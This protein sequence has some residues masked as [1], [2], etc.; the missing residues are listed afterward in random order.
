MK[1]PILVALIG[2][3]IGIVW[4]LYLKI[5]IA[6]FVLLL[7]IILI[8]YKK[9]HSII[10]LIMITAIISNIEI[11]TINNKC[12]NLQNYFS[13]ESDFV[14]TVIS[15]KI[16]GDYFN[17]YTI[18]ISK[19]NTSNKFKNVKLLLRTKKEFSYGD[20][21]SFTG[22]YVKGEVQRNYL[23]FDYSEYLKTLEIYGIC[24]NAKDE[25]I[26]KKNNLNKANL[27]LHDT[28]LRIKQNIEIMLKKEEA[29]LLIALITGD[30]KVSDKIKDDFRNS[31]I[32]HMLAISGMH[33]A[34]I[35]LILDKITTKLSISKNKKKWIQIIGIILFIQLS[36]KSI[37]IL[38]A[39]IMSILS[40]FA[41]ISKRKSDTINNICI[42]MLIFLF[43]N[44]FSI[45]N[46]SFQ[47]SFGGVIGIVLLNDNYKKLLV[48]LNIKGKI[49]ESIASILSAQTMIIPVII[50]NYHT[51]SLTFI[52]SNLLAGL[53]I[54]IIIIYGLIITVISFLSIQISVIISK[55]LNILIQMLI[56]IAHYG[57]LLPFSRIYVI[58]PRIPIIII[59]YYLILELTILKKIKYK[60][61]K[62]IFNFIINKK[63]Y[64]IVIVILIVNI[65]IPKDL[66]IYFIDVGQ[67]DSTLIVTPQNKRILIDSGGSLNYD[68]GN[69][70]LL[71]YLLNRGI[72]RI[73]YIIISHFDTD[74]VGGLLEII[75]EL[76][77][78]KI[79]ISKQAENSKNFQEFI[80]IVKEK[81][82]N[83]IIVGASDARP[84]ILQIE[85]DIYFDILWPIDS[86]L[87][88]ENS[89]NNNSI[90][91]KLHYKKIS[92]LFTGDIEEVAERGIL[93]EYENNLSI[94][95]S[96]ILKTAHHGS[97]TSSTQEFLKAVSPKIALIGVGKN[98][99][100]GHPSGEVIKKMENMRNKNL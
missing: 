62:E 71:P 15:D 60:Q 8:I 70:I 99:K 17:T 31:G 48:K 51:I 76:K 98:N 16:E 27:F 33:M 21:I 54:G 68:V 46:I 78:G 4:E 19:I 9:H 74:H 34:Y 52:V 89:L 35:I 25:R 1:R 32:Y 39:G 79:I 49:S 10:I 59:Y 2:Y 18:K 26:I 85:K 95:N 81:N 41:V 94:L 50:L 29:N 11:N 22:N 65:V 3:I 88:A 57:A 42:A 47:L 91:C 40:L 36:T 63:I 64:L 5:N 75:K 28:I 96:T 67:G 53:L 43:L 72:K 30:N 12:E 13:D 6:P 66:R 83:V 20:E 14:A 56:N 84:Q 93:K 69:E 58:R 92:M 38:R 37:S 45:K 73:D 7:L 87:I 44:P 80:K 24:E 82:I 55:P 77:V 61:V 86:K 100:F 90:V 23:G 97:K